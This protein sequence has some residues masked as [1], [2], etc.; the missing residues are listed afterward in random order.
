M[1]NTATLSTG[2]RNKMAVTYGAIL[3]LIYIVLTTVNYLTVA[4]FILFYVMK[5]LSYVLFIVIVGIFARMIRNANGG[6]I[7]FKEVFGSIFLMVLVAGFMTYLYNYIYMYVIDPDLMVKMK[8]ASLQ[9]ME[10]SKATDEQLD[11]TASDFDK[12]IADAKKLNIG[13]SLLYFLGSVVLDCLFGLI[14]A[15]IVKKQRP[16]FE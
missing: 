2:A 10:K 15:A 6:F 8:D 1:E 5:L 13:K 12:Q 14:P 4:N 9:F 11:K 3:G 16:M 7:E